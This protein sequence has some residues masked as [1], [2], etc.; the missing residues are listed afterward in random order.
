MSP[1]IP[2]GHRLT[3]EEEE[4]FIGYLDLVPDMIEVAEDGGGSYYDKNLSVVNVKRDA[5]FWV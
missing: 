5:V 1:D 3:L 4:N 2:R